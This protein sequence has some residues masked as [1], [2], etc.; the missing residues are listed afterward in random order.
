MASVGVRVLF[1][2][3]AR[4]TDELLK[5]SH[6]QECLCVNIQTLK[7]KKAILFY[8]VH[9]WLI[10]STYISSQCTKR[11]A[12]NCWC[13][14]TTAPWAQ[15]GRQHGPT[16]QKRKPK[17]HGLVPGVRCHAQEQWSQDQNPILWAENKKETMWWS[18]VPQGTGPGRVASRWTQRAGTQKHWPATLGMA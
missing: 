18:S 5:R 2:Y 4:Q 11:F 12:L 14:L 3:T 17:L 16:L 1:F 13:G 15:R 8:N 6:I 10:S 9:S 7:I